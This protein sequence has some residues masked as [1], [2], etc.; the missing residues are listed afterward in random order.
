MFDWDLKKRVIAGGIAGFL[1]L[2][3]GC[4]AYF[5]QPQSKTDYIYKSALKDFQEGKYQNS[6]YLFSKISLFSNLKPVSI[7]HRAECAKMLGDDKSELKQYEFLFNNYP[8][9]KLSLKARY[10]AGQKL[11]EEK[12][13]IAQKYF[14]Y[15]I[16]NA[17]NTDYAI[18]SE[19]YLGLLLMNKHKNDKIIPTSVKDD[20]QNYFRHY[21]KKAPSGR[22]ALKA[23]DDWLKFVDNISQD[24]YLLLAN[25]YYLFG[26]YAQAKEL[27]SKTDIHEGWVL[28]AKILFA[29]K[30]Y[31]KAKTAVETGLQKYSAYVSED[32]ITNI[33]D[34]Y[35]VTLGFGK[36]YV[37]RFGVGIVLFNER[38][39]N[40]IG[41]KE[42]RK[43]RVL[44]R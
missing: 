4:A 7:Y 28:D 20:V 29:L 41:F 15:I 18:A 5:Y 8:K 38:R 13:Q 11:I 2:F 10:L 33:I 24:D 35:Q 6:Y 43:H 32:D 3:L 31:S 37:R 44:H 17:P 23:A 27:V 12:P 39:G 34:M 1:L 25:T 16:Q 26:E 36:G 22:L 42:F 9:H 14:E 19:Y 30:D 21:L 40:K